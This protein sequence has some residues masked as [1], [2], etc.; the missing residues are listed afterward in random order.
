MLLVEYQVAFFLDDA[1]DSGEEFEWEKGYA[2]RLSEVIVS[3]AELAVG[4]DCCGCYKI[5]GRVMGMTNDG[6][7]EIGEHIREG[8]E[9]R[10]RCWVAACEP[11][12][13]DICEDV[14]EGRG[15]VA[16]FKELFADP[17]RG[18]C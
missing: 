18:S 16:P 13:A 4:I 5:L 11:I 3:V 6:A 10:T 12:E 2:G 8:N 17:G 1:F 15:F 14:V 7:F 9:W